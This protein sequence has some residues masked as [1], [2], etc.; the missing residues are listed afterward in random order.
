MFE[1]VIYFK[2]VLQLVDKGYKGE[3]QNISKVKYYKRGCPYDGKINENWNK[4]KVDRFILAMIYPPL[5]V[6]KFRG[7]EMKNIE[8]YLKIKD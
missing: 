3:N 1:S 6:A 5:P 7:I 4:C 8:D 2:K